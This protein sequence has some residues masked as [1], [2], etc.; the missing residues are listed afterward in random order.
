[1]TKVWFMLLRWSYV[2]GA[3]GAEQ[4]FVSVCESRCNYT[5]KPLVEV[6]YLCWCWVSAYLQIVLRL[7]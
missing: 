4:L 7:C 3:H 1:M 5:A 2:I 6:K